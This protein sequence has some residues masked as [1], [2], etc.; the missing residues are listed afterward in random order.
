MAE[1]HA[2]IIARFDSVI[3]DANLTAK[4]VSRLEKQ[5]KNALNAAQGL[6]KGLDGVDK[7]LGK[8]NRSMGRSSQIAFQAGQAISDFS[9][10][11]ILGAAN[12]L[13]FLALQMGASAPVMIGL[14]A[15]TSAFIVF[16]D[17]AKEALFGVA[18]SLEDVEKSAKSAAD[19]LIGISKEFNVSFEGSLEDLESD[20]GRIDG[21]IEKLVE[22]RNELNQIVTSLSVTRGPGG[23]TFRST[24]LSREVEAQLERIEVVLAR[25][26]GI[27]ES[28]GYR[29]RWLWS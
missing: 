11:G 8:V 7:S 23:A 16:G 10:A 25:Q 22:K 20:L 27:R 5:F 18:T 29:L 28:E 24:D 12:N 2:E 4:A 17:D 9:T 14:A 6:D 3:K 21:I 13:E 15:L 1:L 19:E 26:E